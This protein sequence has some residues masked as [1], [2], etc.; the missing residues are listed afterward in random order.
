MDTTGQQSVSPSA[1]QP[2]MTQQ[3]HQMQSDG[4]P[5]NHTTQ[6]LAM[7]TNTANMT[8]PQQ[9]PIVEVM[10]EQFGL[11]PKQQSVMYKTPYSPAYN[12]IPL[13]HKYKMPNFTKFSGQGEVSTM[14][15][16]NRFF[17]QLG[18]A[19]NHYALRVRLFSLSLSGSVFA[20]FTTLLANSILYWADLERQFHQFFNSGI[21]ELK[22]TILTGLRQRNDESVA[23]FIQRFR[24]VKNRCYSLV[25]SDQQLA[26]VAFNGLLPHIK[27]KYAS[28]E[29]ESISQIA[30]MMSGETRSYESM[31]PF[32]KKINYVEYSTNDDSEE[33]Q[34]TVASAEWIQNS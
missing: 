14:E 2:M 23:V 9:M 15:H 11:S 18:E 6:K 28:Q 7:M 4:Q 31:K 32:Q 10:R 12:Q 24:D 17:L 5:M 21:T 34:E 30:A 20:W 3:T 27:D 13:P 19:G 8:S 1:P 26:E 29:F 16:V 22:L 25:L 33:E